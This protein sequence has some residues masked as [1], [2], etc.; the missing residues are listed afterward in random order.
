MLTGACLNVEASGGA[1]NRWETRGRGEGGRVR[2]VPLG[3]PEALVLVQIPMKEVGEEGRMHT[4]H[5]SFESNWRRSDQ[6]VYKN[7]RRVPAGLLHATCWSQEAAAPQRRVT[8][9]EVNAS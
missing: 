3:A 7:I 5:E 1:D 8:L 2:V 9:R 4:C 6:W